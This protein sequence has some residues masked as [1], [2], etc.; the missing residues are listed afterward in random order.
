MLHAW[1]A[2]VDYVSVSET[3]NKKAT[4]RCP[5]VFP[6]AAYLFVLCL[7]ANQSVGRGGLGWPRS[8]GVEGELRKRRGSAAGAHC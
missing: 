3:W 7:G 4:R 2:L 1:Y 5:N 8:E 6:A